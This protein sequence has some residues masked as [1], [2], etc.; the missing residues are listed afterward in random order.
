MNLS[1]VNMIKKNYSCVIVCQLCILQSFRMVFI[2][3]VL[4][5]D[6]H[7][8]IS[9]KYHIYVHKYKQT[10]CLSRMDPSTI[11]KSIT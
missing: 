6:L 11:F 3:F 7:K 9:Q 5:L 10:N 4:A 8:P 2:H 1:I